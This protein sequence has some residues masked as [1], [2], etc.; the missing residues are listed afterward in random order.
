MQLLGEP[1]DIIS[2]HLR[3]GD[4]VTLPFGRHL[5][6]RLAG[7]LHV[8]AAGR[9]GRC[10]PQ[11]AGQLTDLAGNCAGL[12][13]KG[14]SRARDAERDRIGAQ[15]TVGTVERRRRPRRWRRPCRTARGW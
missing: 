12:T 14:I 1:A 2:D 8:V 9:A 15:G 5:D 4:A 3:Y 11:R 10:L 6:L 7:Q 13:T